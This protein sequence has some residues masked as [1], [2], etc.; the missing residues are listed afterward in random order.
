MADLARAELAWLQG[1]TAVVDGK[2]PQER[3]RRTGLKPWLVHLHGVG[4][5]A[6]I[7]RSEE[8]LLEL[9]RMPTNLHRLRRNGYSLTDIHALRARSH[10][11]CDYLGIDQNRFR[12]ILSISLR[13]NLGRFAPGF[14]KSALVDARQSYIKWSLKKD[15]YR[16]ATL[17]QA[18]GRGFL[19]RRLPRMISWQ[20][21]MIRGSQIIE[22]LILGEVCVRTKVSLR[23]Q[24]W[25]RMRRFQAVISEG[26]LL[27]CSTEAANRNEALSSAHII[28]YTHRKIKRWEISSRTAVLRKRNDARYQG[29]TL[30]PCVV[31]EAGL[32]S[33]IPQDE[34]E[35]LTAEMLS[36][37]SKGGIWLYACSDKP[38]HGEAINKAEVFFR[39][40]V[41]EAEVREAGLHRYKSWAVRAGASKKFANQDS[42]IVY[43]KIRGVLPRVR[44]LEKRLIDCRKERAWARKELESL[45]R[46]DKELPK[47]QKCFYMVSFSR[48]RKFGS[49]EQLEKDQQRRFFLIH[50]VAYEAS[51]KGNLRWRGIEHIE[52]K[53]SI[54]M[55]RGF[56]ISAVAQV[57]HNRKNWLMQR[58]SFHAAVA[59]K[60]RF[61]KSQTSFENNQVRANQ[62][63]KFFLHMRQQQCARCIQRAY[64]ARL[65]WLHR[66]EWGLKTLQRFGRFCLAR[67][68]VWRLIQLKADQDAKVKKS[69]SKMMNR[70]KARTFSRWQEFTVKHAIW[71]QRWENLR[72]RFAL[73]TLIR[74]AHRLSMTRQTLATSLLASGTLHPRLGQL[75]GEFMQRK[76]L[77]LLLCHI[78]N[79]FAQRSKF[80]IPSR[81][82]E[83]DARLFHHRRRYQATPQRWQL[84][85]NDPDQTLNDILLPYYRFPLIDVSNRGQYLLCNF[86]RVMV[87]LNTAY[88]AFSQTLRNACRQDLRQRG[89][90]ILV[91]LRKSQQGESRHFEDDTSARGSIVRAHLATELCV[92]C[93]A[94]LI[95]SESRCHRCGMQRVI[96]ETK[97]RGIKGHTLPRN[98][99]RLKPREKQIYKLHEIFF[100]RIL[101]SQDRLLKRW[102][103]IS[104]ERFMHATPSTI[105]AHL[106]HEAEWWAAVQTASYPLN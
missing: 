3:L 74:T 87:A 82:M 13:E 9:I 66:N 21:C 103:E 45:V 6:H 59:R 16:A 35:K 52:L 44:T 22:W 51:L 98:G 29:F 47:A 4:L 76:H 15:I 38:E 18:L 12:K 53:E 24:T 62:L 81:T 93:F 7:V 5:N 96:L 56:V 26:N 84:P 30:G 80:G 104:P 50:R 1:I 23:E 106:D 75:L 55:E 69:L 102:L 57:Y 10:E 71:R 31:D 79:D 49:T 36:K 33:W 64:R 105:C 43:H 60:I 58:N 101:Q 68:E 11:I 61:R 70:S 86:W 39:C 73:R 2:T 27:L 89:A 72:Q 99:S 92:E 67:I 32:D 78:A 40:V 42:S 48:R 17:V 37:P 19:V 8:L 28:I 100:H 77:D 83:S 97:R 91:Q 34:R 88:W 25:A 14:C 46:R 65:R 41:R 95:K 90:E 63:R 85:V 94:L 20:R 54:A